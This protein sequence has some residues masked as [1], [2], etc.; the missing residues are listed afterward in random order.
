MTTGIMSSTRNEISRFIEGEAK[1]GELF[2]PDDAAGPY[3]FYCD[4]WR[5]IKE[6]IRAT[7]WIP[8]G[9]VLLYIGMRGEDHKQTHV[10]VVDAGEDG[11]R[12]R[13]EV[14]MTGAKS[15]IDSAWTSTE[16]SYVPRL[17]PGDLVI[18]RWRTYLVIAVHKKT[19][20]VTSDKLNCTSEERW[21]YET[22]HVSVLGEGANH[23]CG[24]AS[25]FDYEYYEAVD[26]IVKNRR[27]ERNPK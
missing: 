7:A 15:Q 10:P 2:V 22:L 12:V 11:L 4:E 1:T 13:Q 24:L 26:A 19:Y 20:S 21:V 9:D 18:T 5:G 8:K 14:S 17:V 3:I 25:S 16:A 23:H 27:R 6:R